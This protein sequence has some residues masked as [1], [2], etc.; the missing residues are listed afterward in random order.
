MYSISLTFCC[1]YE[2]VRTA[3]FLIFLAFD[4]LQ[5]QV[6]ARA[7]GTGEFSIVVTGTK[8]AGFGLLS[9]RAGALAMFIVFVREEF[10]QVGVYRIS[11]LLTRRG[12]W[13]FWGERFARSILFDKYMR[14]FRH[15]RTAHKFRLDICVDQVI[16]KQVSSRLNL[17]GKIGVG[18]KLLPTYKF[19]CC[20]LS[21]E[22]IFCL[23]LAI[24][25]FASDKPYKKLNVKKNNQYTYESF[26][27]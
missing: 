17:F 14:G 6:S 15:V 20:E 21:T 13:K 22:K 23:I 16:K 24:N 4:S 1:L 25:L 7:R 12:G 19:V 2:P 5:V 26:V 3:P 27:W 9:T 11:C 10:F 8:S 18:V